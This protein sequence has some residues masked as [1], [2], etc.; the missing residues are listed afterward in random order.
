MDNNDA[1]LP[2]GGSKVEDAGSPIKI[3]DG[4]EGDMGDNKPSGSGGSD[5]LKIEPK[6]V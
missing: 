1:P 2:S 5:N 4:G 6:K 3:N